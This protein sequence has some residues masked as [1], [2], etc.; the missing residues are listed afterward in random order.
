MATTDGISTED[1]NRVTELAMEIWRHINPAMSSVTD[2]VA[3]ERCRL[4]LLDCLDALETKYGPLPSILA[5]RADFTS[6]D[7][8]DKKEELLVRA[9]ALAVERRDG[10]NALYIAHSLADMYL[11]DL[12]KPLEGGRWLACF[13]T[14][15]YD[16]HD[17]AWWGKEY[18]RL[19]ALAR[20][21]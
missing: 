3:E 2:A 5:T 9:Y 15:L 16:D 20:T 21:L 10:V 1:W 17:D 18:E 19:K 12:G 7:E 8:I 14:H 13:A 11:E 6:E 4:A